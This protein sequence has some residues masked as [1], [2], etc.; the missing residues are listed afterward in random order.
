[1]QVRLYIPEAMS[2]KFGRNG[3]IRAMIKDNDDNTDPM[4]IDSDGQVNSLPSS[5][6]LLLLCHQASGLAY[7]FMLSYCLRI[8]QK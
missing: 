3:I 5:F 7:L 2:E 4:Y 8:F 6:L 1:M